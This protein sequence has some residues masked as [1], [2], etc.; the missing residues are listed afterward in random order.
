MG[1]ELEKIINEGIDIDFQNKI[2]FNTNANNVIEKGKVIY[3]QEDTNFWKIGDGVSQLKDLIWYRSATNRQEGDEFI[4]LKNSYTWGYDSILGKE[5]LTFGFSYPNFSSSTVSG[6]TNTRDGWFVGRFFIL[7]EPVIFERFMIPFGVC[8]GTG[9]VTLNIYSVDFVNKICNLVVTDSINVPI[10]SSPSLKLSPTV[11]SVFLKSG[12]YMFTFHYQYLSGNFV[13]LY[14]LRNNQ[15]LNSINN[16]PTGYFAAASYFTVTPTPAPSVITFP[17]S[18]AD[19][20][21][22]FNMNIVKAMICTRY[23]K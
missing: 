6:F 16:L 12:I 20:N 1:F 23:L 14:I 11:N 21:N 17:G 8:D 10:S 5:Y 3:L 2:Y 4:N 18:H 22:I 7:P 15:I 13:R 19:I 9:I